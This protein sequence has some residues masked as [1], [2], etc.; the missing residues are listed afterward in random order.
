MNY[1]VF[2]WINNFAG[3]S[4]LLD[5]LMIAITNS[6][7]Y[8]AILFML[9]LWFNNGKK[10]NAIRKQYTV[11]YTTL[12]VSIA[13]LVNVLIHAVYYHP[14]PFIT[15]HVNQLVP[16]AADSSFVSDHSVLVFS[17]AFVFILR[18]EKLKYI[19][20]IW[21]ILVGVS[22]M[23]VGVHYPLDILGAAFL[24]FITSGLVMQSARIFEPL[25]SFIFKMYALVAKR[26]PFLA[27]YNH[28]A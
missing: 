16:H 15:H 26:V 24:T 5:T 21:A 2:Q 17:I 8:V 11:L 10:E 19:A 27:K 9:I 14:R 18:G 1:T 25:A 13:L 3:S 12:S 4:K 6:V 28:I 22:R 20:L 7:P 23:Y